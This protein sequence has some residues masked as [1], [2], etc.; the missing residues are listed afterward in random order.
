[1]SIDQIDVDDTDDDVIDGD[2]SADG[3]VDDPFLEHHDDEPTSVNRYWDGD[4]GD[5][6]LPSRKALQALLKWPFISARRYPSEWKAFLEHRAEITGRLN[7]LLL[8][9]HVDLEHAVAYKRQAPSDGAGKFTTL[10]YDKKWTREETILIVHRRARVQ[11]RR[12]GAA[13]GH[14]RRH[15][16]CQAR[17]V[18]T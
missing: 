18:R 5:L 17:A 16:P 3:P 9:V 12:R 10:L 1:M 14:R 11:R 4:R 8:E 7:D 2:T 6:D 15:R 13:G